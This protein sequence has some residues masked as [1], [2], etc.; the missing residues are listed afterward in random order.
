MSTTCREQY[1]P[2]RSMLELVFAPAEKW[3]SRSDK[4]IIAETMKELESL[5]PSKLSRSSTIVWCTCPSFDCNSYQRISSWLYI[6]AIE[7]PIKS[8]FSISRSFRSPAN[9]HLWVVLSLFRHEILFS[10]LCSLQEFGEFHRVEP[11]RKW[12]KCFTR[13]SLVLQPV[14]LTSHSHEMTCLR[15]GNVRK[16]G[17]LWGLSFW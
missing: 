15:G 5:F 6:G 17:L 3:I 9:E 14:H 4:D 11:W 1:D 8:T 12:A 2:D 10:A 7:K 13:K 16:W